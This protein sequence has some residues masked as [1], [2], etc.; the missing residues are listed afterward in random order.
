MFCTKLF[1]D[2]KHICCNI[3]LI[4]FFSVMYRRTLFIS[5][6]AERYTCLHGFAVLLLLVL[7]LILVLTLWSCFHHCPCVTCHTVDTASVLL[8]QIGQLSLGV[9]P[10]VVRR[11]RYGAIATGTICSSP[12]DAAFILLQ[13]PTPVSTGVRQLT[14]S[15]GSPLSIVPAPQRD[16]SIGTAPGTVGSRRGVVLA[17]LT[18]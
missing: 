16:S 15:R 12:S 3:G 1:F 5:T 10:P 8:V 18:I 2:N 9:G 6:Q 7:V 11:E 13:Q 14:R 4:V 17:S